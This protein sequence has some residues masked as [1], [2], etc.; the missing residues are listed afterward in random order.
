MSD[1]VDNSDSESSTSNRSTGSKAGRDSPAKT[2]DQMVFY[3][4]P[5]KLEART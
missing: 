5:P 2:F 1:F 4:L 3:D